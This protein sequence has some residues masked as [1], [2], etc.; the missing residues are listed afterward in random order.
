MELARNILL[1]GSENRWL[2]NHLPKWWFVKKA[3]RRFIPGELLSDAFEAARLFQNK[4]ISTLSTRLGENIVNLEEADE[5]TE[6]YL[7]SINQISQENLDAELSLKLTQFGLDLDVQQTHEN[8]A[9]IIEKS[10]ASGRALWIDMEGSDY[11]EIT[12]DFYKKQKEK[13]PAIGIC[14][15]AYLFRTESDVKNL[16]SISPIIRL[17]KGAYKE[18]SEIAFS[19][20]SKVDENFLLLSKMLLQEIKLNDIRVAFATHDLDI[21]H[22]IEQE[23]NQLGLP[24]DKIEFQMLY[25]I[26]TQEQ[27]RLAAEGYKVRIL[28]S[29]GEAWFAWYMR[30]LAERPANVWFVLKNMFV[31]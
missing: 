7:D 28:V 22:K 20:K 16:L 26:R 10:A 6:H 3:V 14:L 31:K 1:W 19:D 5:I 21:I 13:F 4:N 25:G 23:V 2:Q 11:T 9:K 18:S 15:Q 17:V 29:Y 30:R 27:F 12:I 24:K 8:V